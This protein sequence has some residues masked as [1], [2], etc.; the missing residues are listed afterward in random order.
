MNKGAI[1][2]WLPVILLMM[3]FWRDVIDFMKDAGAFGAEMAEFGW[4]IGPVI[5]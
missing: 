4:D 3:A 2:L 5:R 1:L